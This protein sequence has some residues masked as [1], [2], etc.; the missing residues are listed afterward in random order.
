MLAADALRSGLLPAEVRSALYQALTRLR[1]LELTDSAANLDGHK[2]IA[3]GIDD[4]ERRREIIVDPG[5]GAFIGERQ[6][7][8]D[9]SD[10]GLRRRAL[11]PVSRRYRSRLCRHWENVPRAETC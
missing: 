3:L 10:S 7:L 4:G 5:T 2:G 1:G 11:S 8:S 9:E 6:I